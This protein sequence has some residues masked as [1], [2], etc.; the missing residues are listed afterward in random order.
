MSVKS[1]AAISIVLLCCVG[2]GQQPNSGSASMVINATVGPPYPIFAN[3]LT[4]SLTTFTI[5]GGGNR[6]YVVYQSAALAVGSAFIPANNSSNSI[7]LA[8]TPFPAL[9][10]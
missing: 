5:G 1:L 7:D 8:L 3:V 4:S 6:P 10:I 2:W 9:V